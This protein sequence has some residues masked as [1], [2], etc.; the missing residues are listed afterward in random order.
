MNKFTEL[1]IAANTDI[2]NSD[3]QFL[4]DACELSLRSRSLISLSY[5]IRYFLNGKM[6]Q[7]LFDELQFELEKT[8]EILTRNTEDHIGKNID[9][10][11]NEIPSLGVKF[12]TY[13]KR[14]IFFNEKVSR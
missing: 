12:E 9:Y 5:P 3:L 8:L 10:D 6:R 7:T 2:K 13:K 14:V 1:L 11:E 4:I